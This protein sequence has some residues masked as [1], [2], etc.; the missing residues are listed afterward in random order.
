MQLNTILY[1]GGALTK[2]GPRETFRCDMCGKC[3]RAMDIRHPK[4][5]GAMNQLI[6]VTRAQGGDR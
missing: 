5:L 6:V 4:Y 1:V 3:F 2:P